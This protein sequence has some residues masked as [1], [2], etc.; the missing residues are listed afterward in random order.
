[1]FASLK[2]HRLYNLKLPVF[3]FSGERT[4]HFE[5]KEIY[6]PNF[7]WYVKRSSSVDIN[8][9]SYHLT[10]FELIN[11]LAYI[12]FQALKVDFLKKI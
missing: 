6:H 10:A 5:N 4:Y 11:Q 3:K 2:L 9:K 12:N 7:A 8:P 1:M